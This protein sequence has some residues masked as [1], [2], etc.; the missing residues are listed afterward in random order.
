MGL[1]QLSSARI[2][3]GYDIRIRSRG[4]QKK[5]LIINFEIGSI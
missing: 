5:D 3:F 1:D 4:N 2:E